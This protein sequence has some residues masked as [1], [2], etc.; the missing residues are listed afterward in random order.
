MTKQIKIQDCD[1]VF[2]SYDEPN[3]EQNWVD[4]QSKVPWAKRVHGVKGPDKA[5]KECAMIAETDR[6]VTV[7]GDSVIDPRFVEQVLNF[8]DSTDLEHSVISW[9]GYNVINGLM[10]GN[11][12]L[13]CWPKPFVLTMK[14]HEASDTEQSSVDFCWEINYEQMNSSYSKT[15]VNATP[16]QA[17]RAGFREGVKM[18]LD[19]GIKVDAYEVNK[20]HWKNLDRLYI[21]QMVGAD[22]DNGLWAILGARQGSYL[23][24]CTDYDWKKIID[25]DYLK[26]FFQNEVVKMVDESSIMDCIQSFGNQLIEQLHFP[27]DAQP[28]SPQQS[29]FHKKVYKNPVRTI[30][31]FMDQENG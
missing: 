11:G 23:T 29:I 27:I 21:W 28:L 30:V 4:L 16:E 6:F 19:R 20:N 7:D 25:S 26:N 14:T 13:K 3:C 2:L 31:G 10:Y 8:D 9:C 12:G 22:V 1:I 5:H 24:N 15:V 18:T 17:W